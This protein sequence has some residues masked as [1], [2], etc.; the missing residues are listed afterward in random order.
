[1]ISYDFEYYKPK[2]Y[3]EALDIFA[4]KTEEGKN[5]LYY[6]GGTEVTTYARK[7]L[8]KTG[9]LID[10]KS[11]PETTVFDEDDNKIIYGSALNLNEIVEKTS[12][13]LMSNVIRKIADH[14]V[15]N[16]LSLGGNI[17]GRLFYREAILPILLAE[18]RG[19]VAGEEGIQTY[20]MMELFDKRINLKK[21]EL[22]LQ[23][24]ID[25]K[26]TLLPYYNERKE[27]QGKIDY[28][29]FHIAALKGED[30]IRFAFSGIITYPFRSLDLEK[31][32]NDRDKTIEERASYVVKNLPTNIR[33][34]VFASADFR[35]Y[36]FEN[37]IINTL[38]ELE[39]D[40]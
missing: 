28:P 29:L 36:L 21:G 33:D 7:G 1:M 40:K 20:P 3:Q 9:A 19:V 15:R 32:L 13:T 39:G 38:T 24:E 23:I 18:G 27:K 11:I 16:R 30:N 10:I 37:S 25:K 34:D 8:V 17:C 2:T 5:P 31:V 35:E 4:E 26:N 22:L 6:N 14:T 12:F